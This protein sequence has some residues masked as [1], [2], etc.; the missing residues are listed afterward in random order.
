MESRSP[1]Y[2]KVLE[3][4]AAARTGRGTPGANSSGVAASA[5]ADG[6]EVEGNVTAAMWRAIESCQVDAD[7]VSEWVRL[8]H[9]MR[10]IPIGSVECE[11]AFHKMNLINTELCNSLGD[12]HLEVCMRLGSSR[13]T[14]QNYPRERAMQ[15]WR[16]AKERRGVE[17]LE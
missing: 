17:M 13:F 8:S 5:S 9:Y 6:G 1:L 12:E 15:L 4:R 16:D 2:L 11:R 3:R 7:S 14:Y 10:V